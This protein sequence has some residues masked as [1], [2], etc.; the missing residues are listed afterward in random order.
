MT[1]ISHKDTCGEHRETETESVNIFAAAAEPHLEML[2]LS[3]SIGVHARKREGIV[4]CRLP[5]ILCPE[6]IS[7]QQADSRDNPPL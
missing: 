5:L 3:E 7:T 4:Y 2:Y 1:Q 6:E